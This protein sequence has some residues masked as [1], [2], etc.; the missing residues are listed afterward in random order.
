MR[1]TNFLIIRFSIFLVV[2]I[3]FAYK[4]PVSFSFLPVLL[5]V[6]A[7]VILLYLLSRKKLFQ[8]IFFGLS[9]YVCF[10]SIGYFSYQIRLPEFHP[11]HYSKNVEAEKKSSI[12]LKITETLKPDLFHSKYLAD[13][14]SLDEKEVSGRVLVLLPLDSQI[15]HF[16]PD[17]IIL[18]YSHFTTIPPVKNPYQF[19]Y[20]KYLNLQ[21][22]YDEIHISEKNIIERKSGRKTLFGTAQNLRANVVEKLKKTSLPDDER[23]IVQALILG[24]KKDIDKELY[25]Q[26]AA[27]GAVHILAVS[28]LHVG[29]LFVIFQFLFSPLIRFKN[30]RIHRAVLIVVLLWSFAFLAGLSPSVLRAVS[31]FSF[32]ALASIFGRRTNGINT[33]F[34]SFFT[35]LII[36]PFWLFQVGFQLSYSAVFFILWL[37]P[38]IYRFSISRYKFVQKTKSLIGV[39]LAAQLGVMPLSLY[40]FHQ[41]PGLFLITN[42]IVLPVLSVYMIF[43][44]VIILF[45]IFDVFPGFLFDTYTFLLEYLNGFIGWIARQ[46]RFLFSDIHF[47]ELKTI[48]TYLVILTL[49]FWLHKPRYHKLIFFLSSVL[50]LNLILIHEKFQNHSSNLV[51]FHKS[52]HSL[53]GI[54]NGKELILYKS[55]PDFAAKEN[56]PT[57]PFLI[58]RDIKSIQEESIPGVFE[59]D[60]KRILL[61]DSISS[62]PKAKDIDLV[63]LINSP[64][65]NL[66]RMIDSINPKQ[67]IADGSNFPTFVDR[68]EKDSKE[69]NIPFHST[70]KSGAF[71]M[72]KA[73]N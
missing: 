15:K 27:A 20:K 41:F 6:F 70:S 14:K 59:F 52:R 72:K 42:L 66:Y 32:F 29:I 30:G 38:L 53:L 62:F 9:V 19:D 2:G 22:V 54:Q 48:G 50:L 8:N 36:N 21:E 34:L 61:I 55:P 13:V 40:Y 1:F 28:G 60:S 71:R 18:I 49:I 10:F 63:L 46:D 56:N 64:K 67:I 24:E 33:L 73:R 65:I 7:L 44:I 45:A 16:Q 43:G 57:K 37:Q 35:L 3:I 17:E 23:S 12:K 69:K 31:M 68:W 39:T 25:N 51:I 11:N 4:F 5:S 58:S 47:S 26:Y